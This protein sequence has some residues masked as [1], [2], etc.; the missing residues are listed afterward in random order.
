[1]SI[2]GIYR[3]TTLEI[4]RWRKSLTFCLIALTI[5]GFRI[6]SRWCRPMQKRGLAPWV[7][8]SPS[9]PLLSYSFL[10][11]SDSSQ[12]EQIWDKR[13]VIKALMLFIKVVNINLDKSRHWS[14]SYS[15]TVHLGCVTLSRFENIQVFDWHF[16]SSSENERSRRSGGDSGSRAL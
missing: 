1:M 8:L 7:G 5:P 13:I 9:L 2:I 10:G 3:W 11:E 15:K 4:G 6:R 14:P 16:R 12:K